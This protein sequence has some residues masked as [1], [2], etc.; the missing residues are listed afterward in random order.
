MLKTFLV[1][2]WHPKR[3]QLGVRRVSKMVANWYSLGH[4][5]DYLK[6]SKTDLFGIR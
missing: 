2:N 1:K 6:A 5:S 4:H 3:D